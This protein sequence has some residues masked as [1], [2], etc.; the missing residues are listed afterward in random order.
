MKLRL[1]ILLTASFLIGGAAY[2]DCVDCWTSAHC[3][4][5]YT[6]GTTKDVYDTPICSP[7]PAADKGYEN[8]RNVNCNGC[9]GWTCVT[10]DPQV[11]AK[12]RILK[13]VDV[14]IIH[15]A[16]AKPKR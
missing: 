2:A 16:P 5:T 8:C 12:E 13:L 7:D 4:V 15:I 3:S 14:E 10:R 9:I 11:L 1:L 6:D